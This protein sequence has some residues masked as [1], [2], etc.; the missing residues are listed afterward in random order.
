[1]RPMIARMTMTTATNHMRKPKAPASDRSGL[2]GRRE[3]FKGR[4]RYRT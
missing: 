1:M 4:R 3:N 2:G